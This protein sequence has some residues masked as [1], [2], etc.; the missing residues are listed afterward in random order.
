M[1]GVLSA[2]FEALGLAS[3]TRSSSRNIGYLTAVP[4]KLDPA[5]FEIID[6]SHDKDLTRPGP[7][8]ENF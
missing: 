6:R 1:I 5:G 3:L 8:R 7:R 2:G 4:E